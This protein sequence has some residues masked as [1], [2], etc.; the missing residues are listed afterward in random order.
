MYSDHPFDGQEDFF[1]CY[2]QKKP[3]IGPLQNGS[4]HL[5]NGNNCYV[6]MNHFETATATEQQKGIAKK[7]T[8]LPGITIL[9]CTH[10]H[11]T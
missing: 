8:L 9:N 2:A 1:F 3:F 11:G 4:V 7:E 6:S 10:R 5:G